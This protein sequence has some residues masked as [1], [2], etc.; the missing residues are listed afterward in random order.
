MIILCHKKIKRVL[1]SLEICILH[2]FSRQKSSH[3]FH[4]LL[5]WTSFD[6]RLRGRA[7]AHEGKK[8]LLGG[9]VDMPPVVP[10]GPIGQWRSP[11]AIGMDILHSVHHKGP[12]IKHRQLAAKHTNFQSNKLPLEIN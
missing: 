6:R 1:Q 2:A 10:G 3:E 8:R 5:K 9:R 4:K 11:A 7:A 12:N